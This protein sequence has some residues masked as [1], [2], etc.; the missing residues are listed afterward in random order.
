[1]VTGFLALTSS[2]IRS[3]AIF[4]ML[5]E[6]SESSL[7]YLIVYFSSFDKP[8]RVALTVFVNGTMLATNW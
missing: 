6:T 7:Y 1:M 5:F 3:E 2:L 4:V 8:A